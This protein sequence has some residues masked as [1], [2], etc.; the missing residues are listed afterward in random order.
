MR[1]VPTSWQPYRFLPWVEWR[2]MFAELDSGPIVV[3]CWTERRWRKKT[4]PFLQ[5]P[6]PPSDIFELRAQTRRDIDKITGIKD[7]P[8]A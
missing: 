2:T 3:A 5:A 4:I 8:P 6:P 1:H 7:L